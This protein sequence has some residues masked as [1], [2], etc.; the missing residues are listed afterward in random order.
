[1]SSLIQ[2]VSFRLPMNGLVRPMVERVRKERLLPRLE[3]DVAIVWVDTVFHLNPKAEYTTAIFMGRMRDP[4]RATGRPLHCRFG[5]SCQSGS[6]DVAQV[7][8]GNGQSCPLA[9]V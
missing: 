3:N 5:A 4:S 6:R 8:R 1:M 7:D 2:R 9:G